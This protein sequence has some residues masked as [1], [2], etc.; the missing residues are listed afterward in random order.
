MQRKM[1]QLAS[2][3]TFTPILHC[4]PAYRHGNIFT[5]SNTTILH[6]QP[7]YRHNNNTNCQNMPT[8]NSTSLESRLH[9]HSPLSLKIKPL[10]HIWRHGSD[11]I[12]PMYYDSTS[13]KQDLRKPGAKNA[14]CL[15]TCTYASLK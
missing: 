5:C 6:S 13:I 4:K 11:G 12:G 15:L 2:V 1:H 9:L 10:A 3:V 7:A 14:H 8:L